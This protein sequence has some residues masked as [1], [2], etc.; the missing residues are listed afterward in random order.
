[1]FPVCD[2]SRIMSTHETLKAQGC[3]GRSSQPY[4][5]TSANRSLRQ[6]RSHS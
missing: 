4:N 5:R 2:V 3:V 6:L 1:M